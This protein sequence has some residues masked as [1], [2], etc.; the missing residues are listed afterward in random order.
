M[1]DIIINNQLLYLNFGF[2]KALMKD[3]RLKEILE[4][5]LSGIGFQKSNYRAYGFLLYFHS[6]HYYQE[7][8]NI[9]NPKIRI[10]CDKDTYLRLGTQIWHDGKVIHNIE[11]IGSARGK[12][13]PFLYLADLTGYVFRRVKTKIGKDLDK[14]TT[15]ELNML[16]LL[17]KT[18][19]TTLR[20]I[21]NAKLFKYINLF[22]VFPSH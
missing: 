2:E 17:T 6:L 22:D 1:I 21:T 20:K 3:P 8:F 13:L 11:K 15:N 10:Y 18:C 16:D 9:F 5:D 12:D 7:K 14:V 4:L 19:Y